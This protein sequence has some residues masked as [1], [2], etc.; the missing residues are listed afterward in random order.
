MNVDR[1][2]VAPDSSVRLK[3][4][5]TK[6]TEQLPDKDA[7]AARLQ[8]NRD[9][10]AARQSQL[11][12]EN[13]RGLLVVLQGIDASGKDSTIKHVL[14]GVNPTGVHVTSF[15]VPSAE[16][17]DHGYLWR[18]VKALPA[19]GMIGVFNRSYYEEVLVV[20]VHRD[21]LLPAT[22][23]E[24]QVEELWQQRYREINNFE[25]YLVGNGFEVVKCLLHIS[26]DE[27]KARFLARLDAPDKNWKFNEGDVR[28]REHWDDYRHAFEQMLSHTSTVH[29]PWYV[30][31]ADQK[32]FA[33]ALVSELIAD[34]LETMNPQYPVLEAAAREGL[35]RAR[36]FLEGPN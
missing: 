18:H 35:A 22:L 23:S 9:K 8:E 13:T 10:I 34:R 15:K 28:E 25:H 30:V 20:R 3:D 14:T 21:K 29:A 27:Q 24:D 36:K 26:K 32:Q 6:D 16:E 2:R 12:A 4:F 19:R 11:Y 1:Y 33:R 7:G 17:R 5:P 31:P